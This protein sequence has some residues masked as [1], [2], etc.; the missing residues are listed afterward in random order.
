MG[1][2]EN[3]ERLN[4]II[5]NIPVLLEML[6]SFVFSDRDSEIFSFVDD[7]F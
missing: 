6:F 2:V 3:I 4:R 5:I 7:M 1:L